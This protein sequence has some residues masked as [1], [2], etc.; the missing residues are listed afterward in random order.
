MKD[1]RSAI[2]KTYTDTSLRHFVPLSGGLVAT[3]CPYLLLPLV[4][5]VAVDEMIV[6]AEEQARI[7]DVAGV[8]MEEVIV[9]A[10]NTKAKG[11]DSSHAHSRVVHGIGALSKVD[12]PC[13]DAEL[14]EV[15]LDVEKSALFQLEECAYYPVFAANTI[16]DRDADLKRKTL[17]MFQAGR[18]IRP[19]LTSLGLMMG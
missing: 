5:H 11:V 10:R 2:E 18:D 13:D 16:F 9:C 3:W 1:N 19:T 7:F 14:S 12:C 6:Q 8:R 4:E 15:G 17:S